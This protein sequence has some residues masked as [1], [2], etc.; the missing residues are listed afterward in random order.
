MIFDAPEYVRVAEVIG[1]F[2]LLPS[3]QPFLIGIGSLIFLKGIFLDLLVP[4]IVFKE[5]KLNQYWREKAIAERRRQQL[6]KEVNEQLD[7]EAS[8]DNVADRHI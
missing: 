3:E 4:G 6:W 8:Q 2:L 5:E 7:Q 1:G